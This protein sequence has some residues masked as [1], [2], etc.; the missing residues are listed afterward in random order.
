MTTVQDLQECKTQS[1][2]KRLITNGMVIENLQRFC[3]YYH[4]LIQD[5]RG[6]VLITHDHNSYDGI[7]FIDLGKGLIT[8]EHTFTYEDGAYTMEEEVFLKVI[9][10]VGS[11]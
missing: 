11:W 4:V 9:S 7:M 8:D 1:M 5:Y 3:E 6:E 10:D 2:F